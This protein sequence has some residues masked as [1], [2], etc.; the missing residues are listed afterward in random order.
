MSTSSQLSATYTSEIYR[1][2]SLK[3]FFLTPFR[4]QL[5]FRHP[6][7]PIQLWGWSSQLH[8]CR[9]K[10]GKLLETE[11]HFGSSQI[12]PTWLPD[13]LP[14]MCTVELTLIC[15]CFKGQQDQLEHSGCSTHDKD[16]FCMLLPVLFMKCRTWQGRQ[17]VRWISSFI[18]IYKP[19]SSYHLPDGDRYI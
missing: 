6:Q 8:H 19:D 2:K 14:A 13:K 17:G 3:I 9:D 10:P 16:W 11:T 18:Q 5:H 7:S 12:L 1:A 4:A 15:H